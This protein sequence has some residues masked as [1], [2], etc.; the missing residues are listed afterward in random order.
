MKNLD[1]IKQEQEEF[2]G[3]AMQEH[4]FTKREAMILWLTSEVLLMPDSWGKF[5]KSVQTELRY[6]EERDKKDGGKK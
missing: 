4:N 1:K 5:F 6:M 3:Q 2:I